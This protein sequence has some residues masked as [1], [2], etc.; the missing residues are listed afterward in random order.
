MSGSEE[1]IDIAFIFEVFL[2]TRLMLLR[3]LSRGIRV[4]ELEDGEAVNL[5][6]RQISAKVSPV[7]VIHSQ[8]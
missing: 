7:L 1:P 6:A 4:M 5:V 8:I 2:V 3:R